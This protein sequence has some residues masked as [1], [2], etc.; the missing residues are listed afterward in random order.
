M[1][2]GKGSKQRPASVSKEKFDSNWE[3]IF[4]KRR[5]EYRAFVKNKKGPNES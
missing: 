2:V 4:E 1:A 5:E 3:T